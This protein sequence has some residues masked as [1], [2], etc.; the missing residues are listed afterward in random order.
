MSNTEKQKRKSQL[1][2]RREPIQAR[3]RARARQILDVTGS[4]LEE[5][6]LDDLTTIL[7]ARKLDISVG[8][9]YH[10]FP[11]KHAILY[12]MGEQWLASISGAMDELAE[13]DLE[14]M[15]LENFID[16]LVG[17]LLAVYRE[18]RGLLPLV[19]A[20]WGIPELHELD[21]SHDELVIGHLVGMFRRLGFAC[22]PNELNRLGRLTLESCHALLLVMVNQAERRAYRTREDLQQMLF[23]LLNG[24]SNDNS[25]EGLGDVE[26]P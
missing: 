23:I 14:E 25:P 11:N 16:E 17:R 7:I 19:Q 2:P 4:L 24:R 20:M 13:L 12:A 3:A 22:P 21:E 8:S 15:V 1:S 10:Y 6:G 18:Q 9:L 5:V 26:A